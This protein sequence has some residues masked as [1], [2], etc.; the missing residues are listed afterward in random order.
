MTHQEVHTF[1][2]TNNRRILIQPRSFCCDTLWSLTDRVLSQRQ[3]CIFPRVVAELWMLGSQ[4]RVSWKQIHVLPHLSSQDLLTT[5]LEKKCPYKAWRLGW[6]G[7]SRLEGALCKTWSD[8]NSF[9]QQTDLDFKRRKSS[10]ERWQFH[11]SW[12]LTDVLFLLFFDSLPSWD[13]TLF[14][15]VT[16]ARSCALHIFPLKAS[17]RGSTQTLSPTSHSWGTP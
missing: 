12:L 11:L 13:S 9:L 3:H 2:F 17:P 15:S 16:P 7:A 5:L 6:L 1:S 4:S 10:G 8:M 14:F